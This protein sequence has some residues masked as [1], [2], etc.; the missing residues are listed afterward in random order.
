ML[1]PPVKCPNCGSDNFGPIRTPSGTTSYALTAI[2]E[3]TNPPTFVPTKGMSVDVYGCT[4]CGVLTLHT[5]E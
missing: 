1:K 3:T 2:N 4:E 5:P